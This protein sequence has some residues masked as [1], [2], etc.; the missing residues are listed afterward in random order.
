MVSGNDQDVGGQG[1][2]P[3][4]GRAALGAAFAFVQGGPLAGRAGVG[5]HGAG[6]D[7]GSGY[8]GRPSQVRCVLLSIKVVNSVY[9]VKVFFGLTGE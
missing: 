1:A 4:A 6:L 3:A 5:Q 9:K 7:Q 8:H 2:G